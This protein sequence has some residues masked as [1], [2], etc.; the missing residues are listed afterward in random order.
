[1]TI[2]SI[3]IGTNTIL[4]LIADVDIEN[5]SIKTIF[6]EQK[7]PRI[8]E[9]LKSGKP[10]NEKKRELLLQILSSYAETS[11][12]FN[13]EV[14]FAKATNAFRIASNQTE[15]LKLIKKNIGIEVDV[16]SGLEEARLTFL[17]CTYEHSSTKRFAVID[18]GGG[19][20][21]IVI[22][23]K[24][25]IF[26]VLSLPIGVVSLTEKF[27]NTTPTKTSQIQN[28]NRF[29]Q[30]ILNKNL[31]QFPKYET[32][33]AVAGTPTTLACIQNNIN[34]Y[35]E[36][37]IEGSVLLRS[38]VENFSTQLI[39][40]SPKEIILKYHSVVEGREDVLLAGSMLLSQIMR[41]LNTEEVV[42]S[43]KGLRYGAVVDYLLKNIKD[44]NFE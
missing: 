11:K 37:K 12:K 2:A 40:L 20:T 13:A 34:E 17:G 16:I 5:L 19:S 38:D 4:L 1:M 30:N 18:I 39:Q 21:E 32:A 31:S 33:I 14:I 6:N 7:I 27:F 23:K 15:L 28:C 29:I 41:Q 9:G 43:S 10:I 26:E 42:V 8:G 24:N 3:D 25:K 44:L 35:D 22:G 36:S